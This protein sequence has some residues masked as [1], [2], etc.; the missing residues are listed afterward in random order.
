MMPSCNGTQRG[1]L[2]LAPV[3][4]LAVDPELKPCSWPYRYLHSDQ[5]PAILF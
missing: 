1:M 3:Q 5:D 4:N 2:A